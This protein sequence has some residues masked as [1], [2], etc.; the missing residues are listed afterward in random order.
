MA[1]YRVVSEIYDAV[2]HNY[3]DLMI[4]C[5]QKY[6]EVGHTNV[7][8]GDFNCPKM[9]WNY[10]RSSP[11]YIHLAFMDFVVKG[12]FMDLH[13]LLIS[14]LVVTIYLTWSCPGT[15]YITGQ[16]TPRITA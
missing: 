8:V 15:L 14:A 4:K 9:C 11:D 3:M 10:L 16:E 12:G 6:C 5:L 7:I 1:L 2:A 13:N